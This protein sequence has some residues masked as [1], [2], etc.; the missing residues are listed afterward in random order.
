MGVVGRL[1]VGCRKNRTGVVVLLAFV[2][3]ITF[4]VSPVLA[5]AAFPA[6]AVLALVVVVAWL[7][8]DRG[9]G[10]G[11]RTNQPPIG[12]SFLRD[13]LYFSRGSFFSFGSAHHP[14]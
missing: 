12:R 2:R 7:S 11:Y 14:L 4:V 5:V 13:S 1:S 10:W 9:I 3:I 8:V 6:A